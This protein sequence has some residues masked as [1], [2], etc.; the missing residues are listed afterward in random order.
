VRLALRRLVA[1]LLGTFGVLIA[2]LITLATLQ[3]RGLQRANSA[4]NVRTDSVRIADSMRQSSDD[5]T[6]M[7]RLYVSTGDPRFRDYYNRIL[8]IRAGTAPRPPDYD[9]YYWDRVLAGRETVT[10]RGPRESL[11]AEMRAAHFRADEFAALQASLAASNRL[12]VTE[13]A[14]MRQV[15]RGHRAGAYARLVDTSYLRQ[16]GTIMAAVAR[17]V[18][19]VDARTTREVNSEHS[20]NNALFAA[21]IAVLGLIVLLGLVAV[22]V[23]RR[24]AL[25]PLDALIAATR[26]IAGGDY[27]HRARIGGVSE[28]GHVAD[29][30]NEMG[31]AIQSDVAARQAAEREAVEARALA[32]HANRAKSM[33]LAGMSHE[34]R[35]PMIGVTGMLEVLARTDLTGQQHRLV[36]TAES[37]AHTLLQII[38]DILDFSKIEA[39][40][41]ELAPATFDLRAVVSA[42]VDGFRLP[43]SAKGLLLTST[44][45]ERI[46]PAYVGDPL[47]IRQIVSNFLSNAVKFTQVGGVETTLRVLDER[48]RTQRIELAVTDTGIGISVQ[49]QQRLFTDFNQAAGDTARRFG[50][51]GLGLAICRRLSELMGGEVTMTSQVGKGTTLRLTVPLPLGDE[52]DLEMFAGTDGQHPITRVKP[53]REQALHEGSLLLVAEDHPVNRTVL[54]HQLEVIGF[55]ADFCEDGQDALERF[56]GGGYAFVITD[57]HMPRLDGYGLTKEIRSHERGSGAARVPIMALSANVMQDEPERCRSAGMD[58]F[59][60]KPTTIPFLAGKLRRWLPDLSWPQEQSTDRAPA[61][62]RS[63][64]ADGIFDPAVLED[65]TAGDSALI[66]AVLDDFIASTRTDLGTLDAAIAARDAEETR[67]RAHRLKGASRIVGAHRLSSLAQQIEDA[68]GERSDSWAA[69]AALADQLRATFAGGTTADAQP[70]NANSLAA[71]DLRLSPTPSLAPPGSM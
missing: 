56:L 50:G 59:A 55:Q 21:E 52:A 18:S 29:A 1:I 25:R 2:V 33:F 34:I 62:V 38:G 48:D 43:A 39:E 8:A 57:L 60:A 36:A 53:S 7:V 68:A 70:P 28:F 67:R 61:V 26:R 11:T 20:H 4:D 14:V 58:D 65:L 23:L 16:K 30:F 15:Q 40:K 42:A 10:N 47:R 37:S 44:I 27:G 5:L 64:P 17:F 54:A 31:A 9:N 19:L 13:L 35:T 12:A 6:E 69:V 49:E 32:E 24:Y 46:G 71:P 66:A 51:T 63:A 45:D 22:V 41:L 3:L